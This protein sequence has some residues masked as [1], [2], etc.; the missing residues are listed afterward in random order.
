[1]NGMQRRDRYVAL[2]ALGV[3]LGVTV[4]PQWATNALWPVTPDMG[5]ASAAGAHRGRWKQG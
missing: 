4:Y 1:M 5:K 2:V 3:G